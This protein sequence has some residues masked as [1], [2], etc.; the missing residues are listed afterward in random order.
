MTPAKPDLRIWLL[1]LLAFAIVIALGLPL[2][3][4]TPFG[5]IDHQA[6]GDAVR[7]DAIQAA[8]RDAGLRGFAMVGMVGDLIFIGIY[9]LGSWRAGR[10]FARMNIPSLK[11]L[12]NIITIAAILFCFT[13]Y[14]E[15][16][17]QLLQMMQD[18]GS[19][20]MAGTE[21]FMQPIKILAW[22]MTFT[23]ILAALV[24]RRFSRT[25]A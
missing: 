24:V 17:L 4:N 8:W 15:T 9:G 5:I 23:G 11:L 1:G 18:R 10:S 3:T 6:A 14:V 16:G 7:V 13:D 21:A 12:G 25:G 20:W 19:D 22:I 2:Q